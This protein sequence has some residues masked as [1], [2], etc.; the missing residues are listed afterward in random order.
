[1]YF[2]H[3]RSIDAS[4]DLFKNGFKRREKLYESY[5]RINLIIYKNFS[6]FF[7]L[8]YEKNSKSFPSYVPCLMMTL[9]TK[10][11]NDVYDDNDYVD[12]ENIDNDDDDDLFLRLKRQNGKTSQVGILRRHKITV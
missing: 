1:M 9:K 8:N 12:I 11:N 6:L 3:K 10:S 5:K 4:L 7:L 2:K